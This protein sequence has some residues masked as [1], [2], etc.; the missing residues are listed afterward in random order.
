MSK[1]RKGRL[2]P[3]GWLRLLFGQPPAG[4]YRRPAVYMTGF[5]MEIEHFK[6]I[7]TY[8]E[9][10]LCL[11]LYG[12]VFTVYGDGMQILSLTAHRITLRGRFVRT[13]FS[14]DV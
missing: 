12:G 11:E 5:Q 6:T 14:D 9:N 8:D 1:Q 3:R 4:M 13:D 7:R 2:T 10:K